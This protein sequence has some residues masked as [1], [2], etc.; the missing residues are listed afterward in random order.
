[1]TEPKWPAQWVTWVQDKA[2]M[3]Q[4][5]FFD[6]S[7]FLWGGGGIELSADVTGGCDEEV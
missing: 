6:L 3:P 2:A 7:T 4:A 5:R 1:M